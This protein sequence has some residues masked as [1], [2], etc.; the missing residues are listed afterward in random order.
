MSDGSDQNDLYTAAQYREH[1]ERKGH[2][3][4]DAYN[5]A[6]VT[7]DPEL[8]RYLSVIEAEYDPDEHAERAE[9]MPG[10]AR[11]LEAVERVRRMEATDEGRRALHD[12]SPAALK[13]QTGDVGQQADVSGL[14]AMQTID[15]LID[16]PAPVIVVIGE[17]GAGKSNFASLL[18]QRYVHKHPSTLVGTNIR[19]LREKS[20]WTDE[21]GH[22]HDG[23]LPSFPALKEWLRQDGNPLQHEQT[24]KLGILDELSSEAGGSGKSGQMTRKLMGPLVFKVRKFGGAL[25]VIAHDESSIHPLLWRVGVIVKKVSQK[26]AVVANSIKNGEIRDIQTEIKGIPPTDWRYNDKEAS[27]WSWTD[28][29]SDSDEAEI[30]EMDVKRVSMWT[31]AQSMENGKSPRAIAENVPYSH[32]TVRNWWKEYQNGGEKREWVSDVQT[33]IA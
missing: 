16:G 3:D 33:A 4:P 21:R 10:Q 13:Y 2:R 24:P 32:Q 29:S 14:K 23:Y 17:M 20:E 15:D 18:G 25:I 28:T 22:D 26:K 9:T 7:S 5:H 6:G 8:S 31:I 12:G 30:A 19:S 27:N 1:V 11:D